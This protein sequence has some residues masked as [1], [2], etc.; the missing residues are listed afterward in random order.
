MTRPA[1]DA[2]QPTAELESRG[3]TVIQAPMLE[4][5][6]LDGPPVDLRRYQG[7][8]AT[9][10]NGV[11]A[12]IR[13]TAA[14]DRPLYAVGD[15]TAEEARRA[16]FTQIQSAEGDVH[17]LA[18][19]VLPLNPLAGPFLHAA[20]TAVAGDLAAV[21]GRANHTVERVRL[22]EARPIKALPKAAQKALKEGRADG[23]L[24]Y[25][26]R[27]AAAFVRAAQASGLT[28]GLTGAL[29]GG[30]AGALA[31]ADLFALS[32]AVAEACAGL[33]WRAV[34]TAP[35]P[36]GAAML[37]LVGGAQRAE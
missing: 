4:I 3:H 7:V 25:S 21:L 31:G 5:V 17:A 11:R 36:T 14:R 16:G 20:G 12:L 35:R 28:G 10:A 22:Y 33:P 18:A 23:V 2:A 26:P 13:R 6:F 27:T 9:S 8:L 29:T 1:E 32:P 37:A 24:I 19:M 15:S 30:L 34:R